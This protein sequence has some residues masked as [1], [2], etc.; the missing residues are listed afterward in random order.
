M[1]WDF[2]IHMS[3]T[4]QVPSYSK[5]INPKFKYSLSISQVNCF[6]RFDTDSIPLLDTH[7]LS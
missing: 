7:I 4:L 2:L 1:I 6:N 3:Y 5:D